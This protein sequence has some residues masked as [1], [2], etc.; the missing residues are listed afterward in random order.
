METEYSLEELILTTARKAE[1]RPFPDQDYRKIESDF[2]K[3]DTVSAI[4]SLVDEG[5]MEPC[6]KSLGLS[7]MR[8]ALN[9]MKLT[10]EGR[11]AADKIIQDA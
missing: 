4:A 1:P 7:G 11:A 10:K 2:G 6:L 5:L 9:L 8:P 3:P